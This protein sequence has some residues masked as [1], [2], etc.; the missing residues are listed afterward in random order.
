MA[1]LGTKE[2]IENAKKAYEA[3]PDMKEVAKAMTLNMCMKMMAKPEAGLDED[4]NIVMDIKGGAISIKFASDEEAKKASY[5]ISMDYEIGKGMMVGKVDMMQAF[6]GG[7]VK[8]LQ[9]NMMD[10]AKYAGT[11]PKMMGGM[12]AM[13]ADTQ[14]P[15]ELSPDEREKFK[16]DLQEVIALGEI[17]L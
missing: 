6:M 1:V 9:G 5:V 4:L 17:K 3:N 14:W 13:M 12:G 16:K 11:M 2:W 7:K 10:M 15:D 8:M